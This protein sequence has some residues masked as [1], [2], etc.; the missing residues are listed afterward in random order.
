MV[1]ADRL[2]EIASDKGMNIKEF[3]SDIGVSYRTIQNYLAGKS[4][5]NSQIL[6]LLNETTGVSPHWL[7]LG[8]PPTYAHSEHQN[9]EFHGKENPTV[10]QGNF[11]SVPRLDVA[12]SA[13]HGSL[14][15]SEEG[16]G[17]YAFKREWLTRRGLSPDK[18]AV[19]SVAGDSMEPD[20]YDGDLILINQGDTA[21]ADGR[22]FAVRY[23]G[24]LFVKSVQFFPGERIFL[25]SRNQKYASILIDQD[26]GEEVQIIG[27]VVASMHE[28]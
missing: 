27:R 5:P 4:T 6:T 28:W 25:N 8:I 17:T 3:C 16:A 10:T 7:I 22:I 21:L 13:G 1:L 26:D 23:S 12:A 19:I 14:V 20:L 11:V 24:A 18:L 2:R 9:S 15:E